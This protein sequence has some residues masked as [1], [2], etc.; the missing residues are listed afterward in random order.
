MISWCSSCTSQEQ[1]SSREEALMNL[2]EILPEGYSHRVCSYEA[3]GEGNQRATLKLRLTSE[4]EVEGWL[5]QFKRSS[6]I[7]WRK[8]KTYPDAGRYNKLRVDYRCEYK[9]CGNSGIKKTKNTGCPAS[10]YLVLKR[11]HGSGGRK[12][13]SVDPHVKEGFFFFVTIK[14]EHNHHTSYAEAL[15]KRDVSTDTIAALTKLYENGHSPS[16]ALETIKYDLEEQE[17][18]NYIY[19]ALDRSVC[20]DIHFC[21]RLYYKLCKNGAVSGKKVYRATAGKKAFGAVAG[22][23]I[24]SELG[25]R[26]EEYNV[27]Q[28]ETCAKMA[29]TEDCQL[30]IAICSP[31]MKRVHEKLRESGEMI[32]VDSSGNCNRQNHRV[33]L[34]LTHSPAGGLPLGVLI[35]TAETQATITTAF[36]LLGTILPESCFFGHPEGPL[37]VITDDSSV[38]RKALQS[39]YPRATLVLCVFHIMQAMWRW[40][41]STQNEVPMHH[42]A[43]L[44]KSFKGLIY[45]DNGESLM[46][47]YTR[48]KEDHIARQYPV[49]LKHLEDIF[50]RREEWA[51]Y[52]HKQLATW[53]NNR[54][55]YAESAMQI[56]KE[57]AFHHLKAYNLT[58]VVD[59]IITR[60][61]AHYVRRLTDFADNCLRVRRWEAAA[62]IGLSGAIVQEDPS[63]YT[64]TSSSSTAVYHVNLAM[65]CC[66]CPVGISGGPCQ[67]QLAVANEFDHH[68]D[69]FPHIP[70]LAMRKLCHEIATGAKGP[71]ENMTSTLA[72]VG[73]DQPSGTSGGG[74]LEQ[75][76]CTQS[77]GSRETDIGYISLKRRLKAMF[78]GIDADLARRDPVVENA[79][80]ALVTGY[81]N[82]TTLSARVSAYAT[83]TKGVGQKSFGYKRPRGFLKARTQ[84]GVEPTFV[85][86]KKAPLGGIRTLSRI[87][88][89]K[90]FTR[91]HGYGKTMRKAST[92]HSLGHCVE[93]SKSL[94]STH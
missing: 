72:P 51:I 69:H 26:L 81:E 43:P 91:E 40:L 4:E 77:N 65:G 14:N 47:N 90:A 16:S 31:M 36:G 80:A 94:G 58:Q 12:S 93:E 20:P 75:M 79:I 84:I 2:E 66:T 6:G 28:G 18:E 19:A 92:P 61:E 7:T 5:E 3:L 71:P 89:L 42:R 59:F 76:D 32:F 8:A 33:F 49:F 85:A 52:L 24:I 63:N 86:W 87:R 56:V 37:V 38:L 27:E 83:F 45:A 60:M 11:Q 53:G 78:E 39:V 23:E 29:T 82:C 68:K 67:H 48:L 70:T 1:E 22:E 35:S 13:R 57:R 17:G 10:M 62:N 34:L 88:P 21:Y 9:T 15:K 44:L 64:V 74:L 54:N 41:W 46:E 50:M 73:I 30:V 25:R 55:N